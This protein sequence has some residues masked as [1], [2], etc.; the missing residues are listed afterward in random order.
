MSICFKDDLYPHFFTKHKCEDLL[1]EYLTEMV[2]S[3]EWTDVPGV[4][5]NEFSDKSFFQ[6]N[7][8]NKTIGFGAYKKELI[9]DLNSFTLY[10][11]FV[12][13]PFRSLSRLYEIK[14]QLLIALR[15]LDVSKWYAC[16]DNEDEKR[17]RAYKGLGFEP[18]LIDKDFLYMSMN[19]RGL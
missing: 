6:I 17:M 12:Q 5:D 13:R 18:M 4:I 11:F 9:D 7:K 8:A 10:E 1:S 14:R 16:V 3:K 2:G 19:I 15:M